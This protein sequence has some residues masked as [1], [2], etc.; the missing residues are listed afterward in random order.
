MLATIASA[1]LLGVV[2]TAVRVEV[3]VSSGIPGFTIVGL[4]DASCRESRDRV[5]AALLSS[6]RV[7]PA[8]RMTV[9]LAP[10]GVRKTGAGLD[11]AI[12]IGLLVADGQAPA[13]IAHGRG[14]VGELGLD[15]TIRPVPG[16]LPLVAC[17][18]TAS[19]VVAPSSA[20]EAQLVGRH[21]VR[22]AATLGELL[23]CL[24]DDEPWPPLPSPDDLP[25]LPKPPDLS[26]VRGQPLARRALEVAASGG[27][28]L[29][30][31][32]SPGSGKTMLAHRLPGLLPDL[33]LPDALETTRVHSAVGVALPPGG[34]VRRPPFRAPHH[35]A[36][37]VAMVGGGG[38]RLQPGEISIA[39]NGVLF[40]DEI[41]EFHADVLD[42]LRQPL[43]EGVV[44][45][46]RAELR[47]TLPARLL[48]VGAMNPCPCGEGGRPGG[49]RCSD[50]A[51]ARYARRLSGPLLDR[52]DLRIPVN[53]PEPVD[54][55]GGVAGES[56]VTVAE[57]V[58]AARGRAWARGV[59]C[60]A[61]LPARALEQAAPLSEAAQRLLERLVADGRLSGRGVQRVRRVALT[62]ADLDGDTPP[63]SH[64][65]IAAA[66]ALRTQ[67]ACLAERLAV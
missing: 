2:G 16:A 42:A 57:R 53:R 50:A 35:H 11:L 43:E 3:H 18:D 66:H 30:M 32:G 61:E 13:H 63:L 54:L 33:D 22:V 48:L 7:W 10:T 39:T 51:L 24:C 55:V 49:C 47:A 58:A 34:L 27:H 26:D 62:I 60:N 41:A 9:N 28:H 44:R 36:S 20:V 15:G 19:V 23:A 21:E 59:R 14:F 52:F 31:T 6:E 67:P 25:P 1:T 37:A 38:A 40:L 29:L 65:H 8:R 56:T 12:A 17:L 4:P 45:V 46:A 64:D 5:R